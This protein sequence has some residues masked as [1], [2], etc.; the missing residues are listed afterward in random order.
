MKE[1]AAIIQVE[2]SKW[3]KELLL[4]AKTGMT[5]REIE[6]YRNHVWREGIEYQ[7]TSSKGSGNARSY[8]YNHAEI[9]RRFD[10]QKAV[11]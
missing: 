2:A 6:N 3:I 5:S 7:R 4:I 9:D 11:A 8:V 10:N 1:P